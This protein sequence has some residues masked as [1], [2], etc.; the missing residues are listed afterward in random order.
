MEIK[1]KHIWADY[2]R[3]VATFCVVFLHSASPL[4]YRYN[5]LPELY[6]MIG[7]IYDSSVRMCIPFFF[8]LSGFVIA[9]SYEKRIQEGG[10]KFKQFILLRL[11]GRLYPLHIFT[12]VLFLLYILIKIW[13]Y[14]SYEI[15]TDPRILHTYT[16]FFAN[17]FMVHGIIEN[18]PSCGW[19]GPSWTL[20]V[21]LFLY[22]ILRPRTADL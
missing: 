17:L 8:M 13:V 16:S 12:L 21:E 15:G 22:I 9:F 10:I 6:W 5:E 1:T 19:N 3:V 4:L 11:A 20:S 2:I 18:V 14:N 7:N